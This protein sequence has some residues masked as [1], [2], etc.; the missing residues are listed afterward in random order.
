MFIYQ[1]SEEGTGHRY[2]GKGN[3][4]ACAVSEHDGTVFVFMADGM[5]SAARGGEAAHAA[6]ST[7]ATLVPWTFL[8][9]DSMREASLRFSVRAAFPIAYNALVSTAAKTDGRT[10]DLLTTFMCAAYDTRSHTLEYGF[11]GDGGIVALTCSGEVRLLTKAV[12]GT[13]IGSTT[14]LHSCESWLFGTCENVRSFFICTDGMF[15]RLCPS[16]QLPLNRRL[17]KEIKGLLKRPERMSAAQLRIVLDNA[18]SCTRESAD[19]L[20]KLMDGVSD[21]RTLVLISSKERDDARKMKS[22]PRTTGPE[23]ITGA[24]AASTQ[25][26]RG[27]KRP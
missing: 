7:A 14:P 13:T 8:S 15:D 17:R 20:G 2:C 25:K 21:D 18:F 19:S 23:G 1:F 10:Q 26:P 24:A 9:H 12:K 27:G 5:G 3:Q 4:D 6:V 22:A 16:G 11:C